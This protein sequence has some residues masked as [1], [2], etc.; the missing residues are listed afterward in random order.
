VLTPPP[1]EGKG[2]KCCCTYK[3][4]IHFNHNVFLNWIGFN[5]GLN[6][7]SSDGYLVFNN[8]NIAS[9]ST[10]STS[11]TPVSNPVIIELPKNQPSVSE[12]G[13]F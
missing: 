1:I 2:I 9:T 5:S 10:P 4:A 8:L 13:S 7:E 3:I 12:L 6:Q 11:S